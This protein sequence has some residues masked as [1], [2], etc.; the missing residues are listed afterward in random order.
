MKQKN[1]N[2]EKME[3]EKIIKYALN[4]LLSNLEDDVLEDL[5]EIMETNDPNEIEYILND[6]IEN[7]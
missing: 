5:G 1:I 6:L 3:Q 2:M 7:Y 4:F